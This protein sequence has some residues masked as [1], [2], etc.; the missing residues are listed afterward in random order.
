MITCS[1]VGCDLAVVGGCD[2]TFCFKLLPPKQQIV[3]HAIKI[4]MDN[5]RYNF[6]YEEIW[7][8]FPDVTEGFIKAVLEDC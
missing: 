3:A 5:S 7:E 2:R 8:V 6:D 4:L 1:S